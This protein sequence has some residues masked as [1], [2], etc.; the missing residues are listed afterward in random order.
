MQWKTY[1]N[2][3]RKCAKFAWMSPYKQNPNLQKW[4]QFVKHSSLNFEK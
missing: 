1:D 4:Q 3:Q 2:I